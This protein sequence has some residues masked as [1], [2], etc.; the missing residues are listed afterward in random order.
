MAVKIWTKEAKL[1]RRRGDKRRKEREREKGTKETW[2]TRLVDSL[3]TNSILGRVFARFRIT[4]QLNA[5]SLPPSLER[6]A[7]RI[8][9]LDFRLM[10]LLFVVDYQQLWSGIVRSRRCLL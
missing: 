2:S 5:C 10:H 7:V 9:K 6:L 1:N 8:A 4:F 3:I